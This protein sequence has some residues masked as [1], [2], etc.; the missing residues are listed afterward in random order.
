MPGCLC[1]YGPVGDLFDLPET[2]QIMLK[3][4]TSVWP[5]L[6]MFSQSKSDVCDRKSKMSWSGRGT[7]RSHQEENKCFFVPHQTSK[8]PLVDASA[9]LTLGD[10]RLPQP[11]WAGDL[12]NSDFQYIT[13]V[14]TYVDK[15]HVKSIWW[16]YS[17]PTSAKPYKTSRRVSTSQAKSSRVHVRMRALEPF[18][19]DADQR[20]LQYLIKIL[21]D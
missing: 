17:F 10:E 2:F 3:T 15:S 9:D 11:H 6:G 4:W 16:W 20:N 12:R 1:P 14:R 13:V 19:V 7:I 5:S 21:T 18:R 8:K